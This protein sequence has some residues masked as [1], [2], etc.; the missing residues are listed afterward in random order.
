MTW[1]NNGRGSILVY[2]FKPYGIYNKNV[3]EQVLSRI[4]GS[5]SVIKKVFEVRFDAGM[6]TKTLREINP[7]VVLGLG[8]HPRAR[9]LRIER[10][11]RNIKKNQDGLETTIVPSGPAVRFANLPLP[12]TG[13]TTVTYDA[14]SYVCNYSMYLTGQFCEKSGGRFG[15]IHIPKEYDLSVLKHYLSQVI[16]KVSVVQKTG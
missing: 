16:D 12:V 2:A 10:K 8:Q 1:I 15:F 13:Q 7:A 5:K 9:K 4:P 14:G 6:F 3:S 11:A